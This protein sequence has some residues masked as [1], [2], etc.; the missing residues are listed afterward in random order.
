MFGGKAARFSYQPMPMI[1]CETQATKMLAY[2]T[3]AEAVQKSGEKISP[4]LTTMQ[5]HA[6]TRLRF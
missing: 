2:N 4:V 5:A 6:L 1:D 3:E